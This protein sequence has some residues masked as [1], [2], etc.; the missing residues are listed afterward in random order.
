MIGVNPS[1]CLDMCVTAVDIPLSSWSSTGTRSGVE[2]S[3]HFCFTV[4]ISL[5][6]T[7]VV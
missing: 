2:A 7:H 1:E 3:F 5:T 6:V 4:D